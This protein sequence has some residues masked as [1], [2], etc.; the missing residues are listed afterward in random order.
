MLQY[1]FSL[2]QLRLKIGV[3]SPYMRLRLGSRNEPK[4]SDCVICCSC[5]IRNEIK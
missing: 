3:S 2:S 5:E 4:F 1:Y